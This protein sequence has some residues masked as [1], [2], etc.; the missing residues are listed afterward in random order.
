MSAIR[1]LWLRLVFFA[2]ALL[3]ALEFD[4]IFDLSGLP[5]DWADYGQKLVGVIVW[6]TIAM[7]AVRLVKV[8]F[9]DGFVRRLAHQNP[10]RLVI[11]LG[12]LVIWF[13]AASGAMTYTFNQ[14]VTA[15]WTASGAL[16][17][18]IG[19]ALRNLILD[20][21]SGVAISMERPFSVGD[22][23][24]VHS[25]MGNFIG[26]VE[27]TN[28]RTTR[29]WTTDRN[30]IIVPNSFM[31]TTIVTNFARPADQ[32]RF[33]LD[34][35]LDFSVN[36]ARAIRVIS[37]AAR[38]AIGSKGP[39]TDP[40]PKVRINK[41]TDYGV[42][43]RLRYYLE[44]ASV[45]PS[46]AR[47]TILTAV[48]DHLAKAGMTLSYPKTDVFNATMPWRQKTWTNRKDQVSQLGNLSLFAAL[49]ESDL[50]FLA[51]HM[52][53]HDVRRKEVLVSM[54][55]Q[56]DSMFILAEG[57]LDVCILDQEGNEIRVAE[58]APGTFFGEKSLLTG[59]PRS[60]TVMAATEAVVC[61]ITRDTMSNL[62]EQ[63]IKVAE[64]LSRAV[65][66]RELENSDAMARASDRDQAENLEQETNQFLGKLLDFFGKK[67]G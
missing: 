22:F 21:F 37:A 64:L 30:M 3:L 51:S 57:M 61:E 25:R 43:Y 1:F 56:G 11:Q 13:L 36:S 19:F 44:P 20:T 66:A 26:R 9:W 15:F 17:L 52:L 10:P 24:T 5:K 39:L 59:D 12:N 28:W 62:L 6:I 47:N 53:V 8:L 58:L 32:S 55:D 2:A 4:L 33:E 42:E 63:N 67:M 27:E 65:A 35:V 16:G 29:L 38:Q 23:I 60:A 49:S 40:A 48:L 18:V 54:G 41:V 7:L 31:T 46:K 34:F 45:S 14:P 50:E